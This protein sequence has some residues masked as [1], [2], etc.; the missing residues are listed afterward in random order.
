[1]LACGEDLGMVPD[2]VTGVMDKER[3]LSLEMTQMDKGRPWP[4]LSVCATSSHDME[5]LRMQYAGGHDGAD[6]EPWQCRN[7]LW[8]HVKS[9]SMLAIFPIQDWMSLDPALRRK[10]F[11]SERINYP[12]DPHNHWKYRMHVGLDELL[13]SSELKVQVESLIRDSGRYICG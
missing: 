4:Y 2:C 6:P 1:M 7:I 3:I 12:A 10:D 11:M 8:D 13:A 5:T 9:A